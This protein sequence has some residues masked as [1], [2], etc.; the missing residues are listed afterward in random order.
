M[1]NFIIRPLIDLD[2]VQILKTMQS[3]RPRRIP[4][5][6]PSDNVESGIA[7]INPSD[8]I[9]SEEFACTDDDYVDA[10]EDQIRCVPRL[11]HDAA[12]I[13]DADPA[14]ISLN[15]YIMSPIPEDQ[16]VLRFNSFGDFFPQITISGPSVPVA[17]LLCLVL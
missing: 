16:Q 8:A 12:E 5:I 3:S 15:V 10:P 9:L 7:S 11:D 14:E 6:S 17:T 13:F 2:V 4:Q 1:D